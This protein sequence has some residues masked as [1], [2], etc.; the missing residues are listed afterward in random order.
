MLC[1]SHSVDHARRQPAF[2]N[3]Q[4]IYENL[5]EVLPAGI[6]ERRQRTTEVVN[7]RNLRYAN[8]RRRRIGTASNDV[9]VNGLVLISCSKRL[10]VILLMPASSSEVF[11]SLPG[12]VDRHVT[13]ACSEKT[14]CA[15]GNTENRCPP[16]G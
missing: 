13:I 4:P 7:S 16:H 12:R 1:N 10:T 14:R 9:H 2:C 5:M 11:G 3:E 8:L 6:V 15:Y